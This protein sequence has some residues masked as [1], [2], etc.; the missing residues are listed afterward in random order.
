MLVAKGYVL[1]VVERV[2]TVPFQAL[3]SYVIF[4]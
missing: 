2:S 4:T 1:D 3:G